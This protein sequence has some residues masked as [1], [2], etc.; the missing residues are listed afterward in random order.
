VG[1]VVENIFFNKKNMFKLI[2]FCACGGAVSKI[3]MAFA[4]VGDHSSTE[5]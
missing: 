4:F 3:K 5:V 1:P 2:N